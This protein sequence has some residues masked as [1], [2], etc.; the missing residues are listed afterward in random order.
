MVD[1]GRA[2]LAHG[3]PEQQCTF[4]HVATHS[5][6]FFRAA[7]SLPSD[8]LQ[9][10]QCS[11][12]RCALTLLHLSD[13]P[14]AASL[15]FRDALRDELV[16]LLSSCPATAGW[17]RAHGASPLEQQ[18]QVL[19]PPPPPPDLAASGAAAGASSFL[20]GHL[21]CCMVGAFTDSDAKAAARRLH[22]SKPAERRELMLSMR[23]L[24]LTSIGRHFAS[25]KTRA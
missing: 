3:T 15:A 5:I 11:A 21:A 8:P 23:L 12:C 25:L 14:A 13:C 7:S 19:F 16:L 22:L 17:L 24:F 6:H 20:F 1:L 2:V 4:L 18:L 10:L 9:Q